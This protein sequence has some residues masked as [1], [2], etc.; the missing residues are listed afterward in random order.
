[1]ASQ[2]LHPRHGD[3]KL[4]GTPKYPTLP[5]EEKG[6]CP[7]SATLKTLGDGTE[8]MSPSNLWFWKSTEI[9]TR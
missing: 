5:A 3:S 1:M 8:K 2:G 7:T 4:G 9:K 6:L